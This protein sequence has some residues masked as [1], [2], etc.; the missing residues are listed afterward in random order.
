MRYTDKPD[1][2]VELVPN[3]DI[4]LPVPGQKFAKRTPPIEAPEREVAEVDWQQAEPLR[5][6]LLEYTFAPHETVLNE[7]VAY[8]L[9]L[10]NIGDKDHTFKAPAFLRAIA[11][12]SLNMLPIDEPGV[13]KYE[14]DDENDST[15]SEGL[16]RLEV[17]EIPPPPPLG[18]SDEDAAPANPF[19]SGNEPEQPG[20]NPFDSGDDDEEDIGDEDEDASIRPAVP[21]AQYAALRATASVE[22]KPVSRLRAQRSRIGEVASVDVNPATRQFAGTR[23]SINDEIEDDLPT[24]PEPA[25][26]KGEPTT[27]RSSDGLSTEPPLRLAQ[28][29]TGDESQI[30]DD[31]FVYR[32]D[33]GN[34]IKPPG[35]EDEQENFEAEAGKDELETEDQADSASDAEAT[36]TEVAEPPPSDDAGTNQPPIAAETEQDADEADTVVEDSELSDDGATDSDAAMAAEEEE[37]DAADPVSTPPLPK[38]RTR[39][40]ATET[41]T[42]QNGESAEEAAEQEDADS[43]DAPEDEDL[44][45]LEDDAGDDGELPNDE[46]GEIDGGDTAPPPTQA[47]EETEPEPD[48]PEDTEGDFVEIEPEVLA[49]LLETGVIMVPAHRSQL[50]HFVAVRK[51]RYHVS[52]LS[53]I[54]NAHWMKGTIII[55]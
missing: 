10:S 37:I 7:G 5:I 1:D 16:L 55:E 24:Q 22:H 6:M 26:S 42:D 31:D 3:A 51:G 43:E 49:A 4:E 44:A 36:D 54:D 29:L 19:D 52:T 40:V 32:P 21:G 50:I 2:A 27:L 30:E 28:Q 9:I 20:N 18:G 35:A 23:L 25:V 33:T 53:F 13:A 47:A 11:V 8:R 17:E 39:P 12:R 45:D 15:P 34:P 46:D 48:V 14:R 41:T 38:A